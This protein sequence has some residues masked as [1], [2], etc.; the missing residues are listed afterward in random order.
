MKYIGSTFKKLEGWIGSF[1]IGVFASVLKPEW[2]DQVLE[3]TGR[4]SKR[5]RKLSASFTVWLVIAM[6][7]YRNLSIKNVLDRMGNVLGMG[8][9]WEKGKT[10]TSAS[11]VE[12]RDR[13]GVKPLRELVERFRAWLLETFREQMSWKGLLLLALDGTTFKVPDSDEN[14]KHFGLPGANRGRA[15][16]P[17]MRAL[18][19]ASTRLRFMLTGLFAPYRRAEIHM[20]IQMVPFV[21]EG[22]LLIMD[23]NFMAW[24]F[25]LHLRDSGNH[26]LVR[27]K[28]NMLGVV[29]DTLG[30]GDHLVEMKVPRHVRSRNRSFPKTVMVREI[31]ARI[32]GRDF[33][34]FTSLLDPNEYTTRDLV[35]L[36]STRW[37]EETAFDEIKTHQCGAT[38]VNRPV[39]F[40]CKRPRLVFQEAYGI[41]L[42]Y[43]LVR[44]LMAQAGELTEV[45]AL[46][47]SFV[48]SL[49]RIRSAALL[50]AAAPTPRLPAM[51]G[52]LLQ[53]IGTCTLPLRK[54][55]NPR[56]VCVKMSGYRRKRKAA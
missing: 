50:M 56:E 43:N 30:P 12:A 24:Q 38:T 4:E 51:F 14:R 34:Y 31:S 52:E 44:V 54:R 26:F 47:I 48:D 1:S 25:L 18:F 2:I 55:D 9:L 46:R 15:A 5:V 36:Y 28:R 40:R 10:P 27:A 22:S 49:E 39:I 17:Q 33:R 32:N 23:R 7:F 42:A 6:G 3:S 29:L 35:Y 8:S 21:P 13:L 41:V 19:L 11:T 53:S 37:E 16:Y 45:P 20:A